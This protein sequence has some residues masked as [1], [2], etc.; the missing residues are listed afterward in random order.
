MY[1]FPTFNKTLLPLHLDW[2]PLS[3]RMVCLYFDS[4][5]RLLE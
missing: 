5:N 2:Y 3:V 1:S 4:N